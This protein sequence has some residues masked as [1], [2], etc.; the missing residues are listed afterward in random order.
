MSYYS[1]AYWSGRQPASGGGCYIIALQIVDD[2]W[3]GCGL[4]LSCS[5]SL[6]ALWEMPWDFPVIWQ[7]SQVFIEGFTTGMAVL[8][9]VVIPAVLGSHADELGVAQCLLGLLLL[10]CQTASQDICLPASWPRKHVIE[11][12]DYI[13]V[14]AGLMVGFLLCAALG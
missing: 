12:Y 11:L 4:W 5:L 10:L 8:C 9:C 14:P 13:T 7:W 1:P 2:L 6:Q 3:D